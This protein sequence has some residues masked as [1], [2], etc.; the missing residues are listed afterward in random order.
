MTYSDQGLLDYT[1]II[2]KCVVDGRGNPLGS[3]HSLTLSA[4]SA[5]GLTFAEQG[6]GAEALDVLIDVLDAK[7][8]TIGRTDPATMRTARYIAALQADYKKVDI[9]EDHLRDILEAKRHAADWYSRAFFVLQKQS[10]LI[11]WI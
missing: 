5:L 6:R 7:I 11:I 8:K 2:F 4:R 10:T 1:K 3:D 9:A